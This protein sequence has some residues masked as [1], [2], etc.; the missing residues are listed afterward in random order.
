VI[1]MTTVRKA[2]LTSA[3]VLA[4]AAPT[5]TPTL[6]QE[7]MNPLAELAMMYVDQQGNTS[8]WRAGRGSHERMMRV[9]KPVPAGTIFYRSGG[10]LYMAQNRRAP[11]G[12]WLVDEFR[13]DPPQ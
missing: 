7:G 1:V 3:V 6:A 8:R 13:A 4:C 2:L 9:G 5:A 10:K 12:K 11:N